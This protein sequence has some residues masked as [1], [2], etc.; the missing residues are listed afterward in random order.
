MCAGALA[1]DE[2]GRLEVPI[3]G[4]LPRVLLDREERRVLALAE[5]GY[6]DVEAAELGQ[7]LPHGRHRAVIACKLRRLAVETRDDPTLRAEPGGDRLG[8]LAAPGHEAAS[9]LEALVYSH[10][11]IPASTPTALGTTPQASNRWASLAPTPTPASPRRR[12]KLRR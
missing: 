11:S 2:E 6:E 7:R 10:A 4:A 9:A 8:G 1:A 12:R 3:Q 5:R